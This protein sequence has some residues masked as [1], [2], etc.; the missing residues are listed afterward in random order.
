MVS[1]RRARSAASLGSLTM[2]F[3]VL[4]IMAGPVHSWYGVNGIFFD[5]AST[6][7]AYSSYYATLNAFVKAKGGTARTI[8]NP[9]HRRPTFSPPSRALTAIFE[10]VLG[11]S[12]AAGGYSSNSRSMRGRRNRHARPNRLAGSSPRRAR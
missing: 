10:C 9:G 8:L 6:N 1:A 4:L 12:L 11:P 3:A 7:C 2:L 5:Q